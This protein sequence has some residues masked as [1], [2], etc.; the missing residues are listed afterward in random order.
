MTFLLIAVLLYFL[1]TIIG[2]TSAI[3]RNLSVICCWLD[4]DRMV[5]RA[6]LGVRFGARA[7]TPCWCRGPAVRVTAAD[8]ARWNRWS[9]IS[10]GLAVRHL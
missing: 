10:A 9:A 5:Y 3:R 6:A 7:F 2:H 4:W 1:P 8:A